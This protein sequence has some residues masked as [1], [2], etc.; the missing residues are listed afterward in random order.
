MSR[1]KISSLWLVTREYAGI[2]EAG[3]VKNVACSLAEGLAR[4]GVAVTAFIPRYG[5]V[6]AEGKRLFTASIAAG[7]EIHTVGFSLLLRDGVDIVFVDSPIFLEKFAVYVYTDEEATHIPGAVRGKGHFDVDMMNI[8]FQRSVLEYALRQGSAPDIV[9][10]QD[11]HTASLP[12]IART[13]SRF[14]DVFRQSGFVVTIH[15]AGPGYRQTIQGL[16]QAMRVTG[17]SREAI[18]PA[19]FDGRFEPFL[20]AAAYARL[21]TVSPWYAAELTS[22]EG[23]ANSDGLAGEFRRRGVEIDG[24]TNGIDYAR[25]DPRDPSVSLLPFGFDPASGEFGG[26]YLCRSAFLEGLDS[27]S[28]DSGVAL[29]GSIDPDPHA[30]FFSYHGRVAWQKGID[31]LER[32]AKSVLDALP[33]ARFL[34]LGQGDPMLETLLIRMASR[35]SGRFAYLR[36]YERSLARMAVAVSDFIVLPSA[37][38]PCG[39]EDFIAQIYGTIPVAHAV[40]GLRKIRDGEN[41]YLY[42]AGGTDDDATVLSRLLAKLGS[43]VV[44][45]GGVGC[46][47]VGDYARLIE[48]GAR[49]VREAYSWERIIDARYMPLY[50]NVLSSL[51]TFSSFV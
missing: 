31:V 44:E 41:G 28:P 13:D 12:A 29:F 47:S 45:S 51:D 49:E 42:F 37:F 18:A 34:I 39:L 38:E 22:D 10:C 36:G 1:S 5:C 7:G 48:A 3:G 9:H 26:K 46:A 50:E 11:A 8:L 40:G 6:A 14:A 30:V 16:D 4:A 2:A 24:I 17:L 43:R 21:S 20:L 35:Y 32:A 23:N 33:H 25:Y 27:L 15:N 19:M